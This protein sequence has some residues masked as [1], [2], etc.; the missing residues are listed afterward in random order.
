KLSIAAYSLLIA[1]ILFVTVVASQGR[2][3]I[4]PNHPCTVEGTKITHPD[5]LK[6]IGAKPVDTCRVNGCR[7]KSRIP[8]S[9]YFC[10]SPS[11]ALKTPEGLLI[12]LVFSQNKSK[13]KD[14][15]HCS[16]HPNA[17]VIMGNLIPASVCADPAA[18][19]SQVLAR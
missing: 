10:E 18:D 13:V 12:Y 9:Y 5:L 8:Q 17:K 1:L 6:F 4:C 14:L 7:T 19:S 3:P 11:C 16:A 15:P 2:I